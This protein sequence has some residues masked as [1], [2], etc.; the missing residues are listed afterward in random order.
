M[1]LRLQN[2]FSSMSKMIREQE[3]IANNLANLNTV[4]YKR[5]RTFT[6]LLNER[7]DDE[8]A[9]R[10]DKRVSQWADL[11]AGEY[12]QTGNPLD[13]AIAGNGFFVLTDAATDTPRYTRA[14]RFVLDTE[15]TLRDP[16]GNAVEG[17]GGPIQLPTEGGAVTIAQ[18]GS[19]RVGGQEAGKLRIV[20]F[21]DP[22]ALQ[23]LDGAAFSAGGQEPT[24]MEAPNLRQGY[25]ELSNVNPMQ[26]MAE[27][28]E[29][30]TLFE[31][32]QRAIRTSD[33]LLGRITRDL[34]HF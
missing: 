26:E 6:R 22:K 15:G 18:D 30:Q 21:E 27:M 3:R 20:S 17:E 11:A 13:V 23:R 31:T 32:Q 34:G 28:I 25:V 7:L 16:F 33:E 29:Y 4:G 12:E 1:L 24:D 9:P 14:G 2:S 19:I 5:D 8:G 10:S